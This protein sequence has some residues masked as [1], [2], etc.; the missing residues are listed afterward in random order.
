M[1]QLALIRLRPALLWLALGLPLL[2]IA[3]VACQSDTGPVVITPIPGG[4]RTRVP[5]NADSAN[6]TAS[7]TATLE[8]ASTPTPDIFPR[9]RTA[10]PISRENSL[11][12]GFPDEPDTLNYY[13]SNKIVADWVI[14]LIN[15]GLFIYDDKNALVPELALDI[16]ALSNGGIA[17]DGKTITVTLRAGVRWHD[18][19]PVTS[20]DVVF[21]WAAVVNPQ[22]MVS[23]R[24]GYEQ[25]EAVETPN[26]TTVV[27]RFRAPYA[28]WPTLFPVILPQHLLGNAASLDLADY[29]IAPVGFGP[30]KF[31]AWRPGDVIILDRNP[32]YWR[33]APQL[34]Q[35]HIRLM[36][37]REG[38]LAALAAEQF[39]IGVDFTEASLAEI[40]AL[41]PEVRLVVAPDVLIEH[42][43]FN[44]DPARGPAFFQEEAVR[45]AILYAI[46]R[47]TILRR[48]L[49]G[50]G[51]VATT[52]WDNSYFADPQ[53][54]PYGFEPDTAKQLL[55]DAGW[56]VGRDGIREK[57]GVRLAFVHRTIGGSDL[58]EGVQRFI[59]QN[60]RDVGIEMQIQNSPADRLFAGYG[61]AGPLATGSFDLAG[62]SDG[63][64]LGDPDISPYFRCSQIPTDTAPDGANWYRLCDP[65]LD[66]LLDEQAQTVDREQRRRLYYE[67]ERIMHDRAY[68]APLYHRLDVYA[69][70]E[71]VQ[72]FRPPSVL[73]AWWWNAHEWAVS[74]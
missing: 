54:K 30:F 27:L 40:E 11:V 24:L 44:L 73:K 34:D 43:L 13:Y 56:N 46:D 9:Q 62:Y 25:I 15:R 14:R 18:G 50:H 21:T 61:E 64:T 36:P 7:I 3:L 59:Q 6:P 23:S 12:I 31:A 29:N 70:H 68:M 17:P 67:I 42:Y 38:V 22:N 16:P 8:I 37:N 66:V 39:D 60:L 20:A 45:K 57:G 10:T 49:G 53:L 32:D 72:N 55:D 2:L 26:D 19:Q 74:Q 1:K 63:P 69:V 28:P 65:A 48:F 35:V 51:Q 41:A 5:A 58:R 4:A 52:F 71:R 33:G 47:P